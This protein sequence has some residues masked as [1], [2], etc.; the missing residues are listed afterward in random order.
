MSI[1]YNEKRLERRRPNGWDIKLLKV[2]AKTEPEEDAYFLVVEATTDG[3]GYY[4]GTDEVEFETEAEARKYFEER[5]AELS[6]VLNMEAQYQYD[7]AHGTV[8]GED[9]GI[10]AMREAW[11]E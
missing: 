1:R 7:M 11:G 6:D 5:C 10:V 2:W 9:A 8:N 4:D 3:Y